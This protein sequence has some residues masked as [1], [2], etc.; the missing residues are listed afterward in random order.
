MGTSFPERVETTSGRK[1]MDAR[2]FRQ[3]SRFSDATINRYEKGLRSPE[4]KR[5]PS[6]QIYSIQPPTTFLEERTI[7]MAIV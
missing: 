2:I 3:A 4:P 1:R 7:A 5:S 6:L